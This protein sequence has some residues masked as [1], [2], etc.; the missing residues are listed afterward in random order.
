MWGINQKLH[1]V[2]NDL[3]Q[4]IGKSGTH[5]STHIGI[6][7]RNGEQ[8]PLHYARWDDMPEDAL[9]YIWNEVQVKI[10]GTYKIIVSTPI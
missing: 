4:P 7:V 5:L 1:L 9:D 2:F 6:M 8:V 3:G 10:S